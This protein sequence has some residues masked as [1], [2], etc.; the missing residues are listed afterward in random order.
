MRELFD[1]GFTTDDLDSFG[2]RAKE[3]ALVGMNGQEIYAEPRGTDAGY[4]WPQY[5]VHRGEFHMALYHRFIERRDRMWCALLKAGHTLNDI[6]AQTG[7]EQTYIRKRICLSSLSPKIQKAITCDDHPQDWT[8]GMFI[9]MSLPLDWA[10][11]DACLLNKQT[12]SL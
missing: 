3:W 5:A 11:H 12:A 1:L 2:V 4:N 8:I 9:R 7:D 6:A 10:E